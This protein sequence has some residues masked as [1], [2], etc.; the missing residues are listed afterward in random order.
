M[1]SI[2]QWWESRRVAYNA[3]VGMAGLA[4]LATLGMFS[5]LPPHPMRFGIPW[6]PIVLYGILANVFFTAGPALDIAICR[7]WGPGFSAVGP[8]L[9]RYGFAFAL[10]L[11]LLP[12][13]VVVLGWV[14]RLLG[15]FGWA[16]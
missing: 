14:A 1:W 5:A 4:T 9:F 16:S 7:R 2:I 6:E 3:A 8:A 13:P 11:T 15:F 12:I 10:G